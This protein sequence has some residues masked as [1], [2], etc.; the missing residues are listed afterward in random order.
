MSDADKTAKKRL[1]FE[2]SSPEDVGALV[3]TNSMED[4][5]TE[6]QGTEE[7]GQLVKD[8]KRHKKEDGTSVS[9]NSGSTASFEGDRRDQ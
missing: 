7:K 5:N 6:T 2:Q 1:A 9:G 8:K 4:V 3:L